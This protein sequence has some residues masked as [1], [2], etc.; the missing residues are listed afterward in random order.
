ML[1]LCSCKLS[2]VIRWQSSSLSFVAIQ[3]RSSSCDCNSL[4]LKPDSATLASLSSVTSIAEPM[5]PAK[6]SGTPV[7][8]IHRY[9]PS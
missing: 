9:S 8:R 1:K 4:R 5:Y 3:A 6:P 7:S 2:P